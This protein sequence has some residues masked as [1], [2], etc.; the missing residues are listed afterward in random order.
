MKTNVQ[1]EKSYVGMSN[2]FFCGEP[3]EI[4]LDRRMRNT[5]PHS[6]V[7]NKQPCD[8]CASLMTLG[9]IFISVRDGEP[10]TDNPY[11]TGKF[12]VIKEE[13]VKRLPVNSPELL[14]GILK[15][16]VCFLE[17]AV[18]EKLGFP[19]G[20]IDNTTGEKAGQ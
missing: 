3:K 15:A 1:S 5:L 11:R 8:K 14:A 4:L 2:C 16:R 20:N 10:Q 13:V 7:Y 6:A 12:C 9:V 19:V 17:D 18:W